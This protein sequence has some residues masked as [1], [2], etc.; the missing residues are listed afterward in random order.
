MA[1]TTFEDFYN[2]AKNNIVYFQYERESL[3]I[4][5]IKGTLKKDLIP[6]GDDHLKR[7]DSALLF[8]D[9]HL[10]LWEGTDSDR[11][12]MIGKINEAQFTIPNWLKIYSTNYERWINIEIDKILSLEVVDS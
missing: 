4:L 12:I 6:D 3:G 9:F 10:G 11:S 7:Y 5:S 8:S 2:L 1:V